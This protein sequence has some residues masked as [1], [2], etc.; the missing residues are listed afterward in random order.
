MSTEVRASTHGW[1][2]IQT[3]IIGKV[4]KR[5]Q[6]IYAVNMTCLINSRDWLAKLSS[7]IDS[8]LELHFGFR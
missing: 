5:L 7:H 6:C 1:T 4:R 2:K 3:Q 8:N